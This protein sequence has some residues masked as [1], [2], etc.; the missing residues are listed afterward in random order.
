MRGHFVQDRYSVQDR[1]PS[2]GASRRL[3]PQGEKG[4]LAPR[5]ILTANLKASDGGL[6]VIAGNERVVRARL[7]DARHFW[8]TDR[9]NLPDLAGLKPSADKLKLDLAK[10]LDQRMAK[11]DRLGVVFHQKLGRQGERVQRIVALARDL[12]PIV[13]A[14]PDLAARAALLA[15]ADLTTEMVG[16]FPELQ[17][18]IGRYYA[19]LQGEHPSVC[20]AIEEH[21]KPLGPNDR[22]PTDPVSVTVA[23]ADKL[24]TLV[25]FWAIDEKPTG[26]KDPFALRRAALGVIRLVVGETIPAGLKREAIEALLGERYVEHA[27]LSPL[28]VLYRRSDVAASA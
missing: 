17:G 27:M 10:P 1:Y 4:S 12:A 8:E 22:V 3:L 24:D 16:E 2:S 19:T 26:S 6:Q 15:K 5:F 18:L 25:G 20:A 23:L 13:G 9:A 7:S 28:D 11:L 14:D 21:Y